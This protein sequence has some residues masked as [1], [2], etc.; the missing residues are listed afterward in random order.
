MYVFIFSGQRPTGNEFIIGP[1]RWAANFARAIL[2][3][4]LFICNNITLKYCVNRATAIPLTLDH[5]HSFVSMPNF[6]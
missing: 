1:L 5:S 6:G 3:S 4:E 2:F